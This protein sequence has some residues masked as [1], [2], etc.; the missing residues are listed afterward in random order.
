MHSLGSHTP[1]LLDSHPQ[2]T[3][4]L[5]TGTC[6]TGHVPAMYVTESY[7]HLRRVVVGSASK[8]EQCSASTR[9]CTLPGWVP[10]DRLCRLLFTHACLLPG[11]PCAESTR[12]RPEWPFSTLLRC[13][14][15]ASTSSP[16]AKS[17]PTISL[18]RRNSTRPHAPGSTYV[19]PVAALGTGVTE[20]NTRAWDV[21]MHSQRRTYLKLSR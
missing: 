20:M 11:G 16:T 1:W 14:H 21:R 19:E 10:T 15:T 3:S 9:V 2:G 5:G 6:C 12:G 18:C 17:C 7:Q 13:V 4:L 8:P